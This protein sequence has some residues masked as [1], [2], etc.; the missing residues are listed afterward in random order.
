M[1][2]QKEKRGKSFELEVK[3]I[4]DELHMLFP[5]RVRVI[6]QPKMQLY[7]GQ[8]VIPDFDL[9]FDLPFE[10]GRYLIECQDRQRSSPS[11]L[12]KIKYVKSLSSRNRFLFIYAD[13]L[14]DTTRKALEA[15]GV[16]YLSLEEFIL[17]ISRLSLTLAMTKI[18]NFKGYT[19]GG[20]RIC[21]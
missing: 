12:Q 11:I 21:S 16:N 10:E 15:D 17:F 20:G 13:K 6:Y 14:P 9:Q 5:D 1:S 2:D 3:S 7:D 8:E 18:D 19:S 4:L